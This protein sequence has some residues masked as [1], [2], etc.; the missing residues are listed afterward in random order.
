ME[1]VVLVGLQASGKS[2][3]Y[4]Q[5]FAATH[6]L[7][8]GDLLRNARNPGWRQ[9]E[10]IAAALRAGRSLVV[11]NTNPEPS[12]RAELVDL[13]RRHEATVTGYYFVPDV[14]RSLARNRLREGKAR[15][16][17][18]AIFA[19]VKKLVPPAF[20]EG[21]DGLF[22]V[23]TGEDMRFEILDWQEGPGRS[24]TG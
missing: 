4:R 20:A 22:Y 9:A 8:S 6:A 3:F 18:V 14:R 5:R 24:P 1:L 17:D 11:D 10:Q 7:V 13:G 15:V 19:T 21:F 2:I 12:V 16:P 23:R